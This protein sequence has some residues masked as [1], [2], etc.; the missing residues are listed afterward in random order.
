MPCESLANRMPGI[1]VRQLER[2][3]HAVPARVVKRAAM[4]S[5]VMLRRGAVMLRLYKE[6]GASHALLQ[7]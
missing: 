1:D 7:I 4:F 5:T 2:E 3:G 6:G